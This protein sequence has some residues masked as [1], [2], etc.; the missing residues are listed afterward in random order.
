MKLSDYI[1]YFL[2]K[3]GMRHVFAVTGGA[4]AHLIDSIAKAKGIDYICMQHEQACAMAADGYSRATGNLGAAISTSGPGA[5]NMLTGVCCS[6]YDSIPTLFIT[7]QVA[8]FRCKGNLG[9]RQLGFQETDVVEIFKPVTKYAVKVRDAK[10]IRYE[11]EKAVYLAK[12]GRPGPVLVDVPDNLQRQEI[13]PDSLVSFIPPKIRTATAAFQKQIDACAGMLHKAERPVIILGWGV[14]LANAEKEA[15]RFVEDVRV[16]VV[17]TWAMRY[18]FPE[19]H[20]FLVGS[21]GT[22]GSRYGNFAVQNADLVLSIG[23]RLDTRE[24]GSP[25]STFAREAK[26]IVVD[27]DIHELKKFKV[28]GL[29]VELLIN[30]DAKEFL[31]AMHKRI[32]QAVPEDIHDWVKKIGL[33]KKKYPVCSQQALKEKKVNPYVF[34]KRLSEKLKEG[35]VVF[36][37]TGCSV[38]WMSQGFEFKKKQKLF[39][40]FNNTPMGYALPASIG[41]CFA[42]GKKRIICV[43][44]D[45]GLQ[46]NIQELATVIRHDLPIKIFLI[47]NH[48]YS[49]I[50]QTQD[51]WFSSRYVASTVES[52][53][54]FPDFIKVAKAYGYKTTQITAQKDLNAGIVDTLETDCPAFC[55]VEIHTDEKVLPQVKFG[56]ALEDSEPLL[57]RGEFRE[58]MIVASHESSVNT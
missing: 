11:L 34:V 53:L 51:Q 22:H 18:L 50:K 17:P 16:P 48:G 35:D 42:L 32:Q 20:P 37:D 44:G 2:K 3:Q 56:R 27:V 54:A 9:I 47:N 15:L 25:L 45:G 49:M 21:F 28:L 40:A 23:A 55:N 39:S 43:T 46:M 6:Y 10:R 26:K 8:T 5:T 52:G 36:L 12:S 13:D 29:D 33:W 58:A 7:G 19:H 14:Y 1:A 57:D 31:L 24:A 38:A 4:A 30:Q 41:A